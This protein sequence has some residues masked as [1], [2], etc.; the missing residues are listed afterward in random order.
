MLKD[1]HPHLFNIAGS[2]ASRRDN[3]RRVLGRTKAPWLYR[4]SLHESHSAKTLKIVRRFRCT[5]PGE[6]LRSGDENDHRLSK[7]SRNQRGIREITR[8][9]RQIEAVLDDRCRALRCRHLNCY[10]GVRIKK[11]A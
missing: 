1:A 11:R 2:K 5:V 8:V 4:A 7:S 9:D 10:I 6:V 3:T